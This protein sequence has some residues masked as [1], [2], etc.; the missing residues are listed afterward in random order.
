MTFHS[1]FRR[2]TASGA[3]LLRNRDGSPLTLD[4][5]TR[6][7][8]SVMA[9]AAHESRSAKFTF[10]PTSE[11]LAGLMREGFSPVEVRQGGSRTPGKAD[12]TKHAVRLRHASKAPALVGPGDEL[13][14]EIVLYNAH[15][16][17]G[18]YKL[19]S[20]A[21]RVLC[22]NGLVASQTFQ[23]QKIPHKGDVISD[24]IEGA[25]CVV[26]QLPQVIET[27]RDWSGLKLSAGEQLAFA[28]AAAQIRWEPETV[29]GE[30][31][32]TAPIPATDLLRVRRISDNGG[33]L[34]RTF[35]RVQ[36]GLVAGGQHYDQRNDEGRRVARRT[37]RP[38]A[39]VDQNRV[40]NRALWTLAEEMQKLKA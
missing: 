16:G 15:D 40:V 5:I 36:E 39:N 7:T 6:T 12:F 8:P 32:E 38:V 9:D 20:G 28:R 11:V 27:A 30:Q 25:F 4:Q 37:V 34:W 1:P 14:P 13:F 26:D 3:A 33:D 17:T 10:I 22:A 24:V 29:L 23:E 19:M 31:R 21:Y 2:S 35:N 18:A